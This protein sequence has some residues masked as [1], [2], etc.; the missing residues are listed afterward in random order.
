V[1]RTADLL[2]A[3]R[4]ALA[5]PLGLATAAGRWGLVGPLLA[6]A[7]LSDS[8]DGRLARR[9]P[10]ATRLGDADEPVDTAVAVTLLV[11]LTAGRH[12][13]AVWVVPVGA[14]LV[15]WVVLRERSLSMLLQA[16]VYGLTPWVLAST[17]PWSTALLAA[18]A[19]GIAL[20]SWRRFV[21]ELVPVFLH[22]LADLA[23]GRHRRA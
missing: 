20:W 16:V 3:L 5:L 2:T 21:G 18:T 6:A 11:G 22:G 9:T 13:S 23:T 10:V 4:L 7:W 15:G 19:L 8:L 1:A 12:V 14:L 17:A